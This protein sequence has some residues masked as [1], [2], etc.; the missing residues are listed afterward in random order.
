MNEVRVDSPNH[1]S[2]AEVFLRNVRTRLSSG[3]PE[4]MYS[5]ELGDSVNKAWPFGAGDMHTP[6][7]LDLVLREIENASGHS[8]RGRL[9]HVEDPHVLR[10]PF[11]Y[12]RP[13]PCVSIT[14][15][16]TVQGLP[17]AR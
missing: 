16:S 5:A 8:R 3:V 13:N 17:P 14:T 9:R 6:T 10:K 7:A 1:L 11:W 12:Q 2:Q 15:P 4:M